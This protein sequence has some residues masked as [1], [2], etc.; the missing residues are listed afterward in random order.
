[1]ETMGLH[2]SEKILNFHLH[3]ILLGIISSSYYGYKLTNSVRQVNMPF[4]K[5]KN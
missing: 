2:K 5:I 3:K 1:M 4:L